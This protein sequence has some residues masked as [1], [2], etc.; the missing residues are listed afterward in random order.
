MFLW[1]ICLLGRC[2]VGSQDARRYGETHRLCLTIVDERRT[3][4]S[5]LEKLGL[6]CIFS[7]KKF[8]SYLFGHH[9]ELVTDLKP[10]LAL[11]NEHCHWYFLSGYEYTLKLRR[12]TAHENAD[13]L[14]HLP[15][16]REK[17]ASQTP[18]ALV[19]LME[20]LSE[21]SVTHQHIKTSTRRDPQLALIVQYLR[22]GWPNHGSPNPAILVKERRALIARWLHCLGHMSGDTSTRESSCTSGV[23]LRAWPNESLAR[24]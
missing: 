23:G 2:C 14:S 20:Y 8:H 22:S 19:L 7:I 11:L 24:M 4:Y 1:C 15:L 17:P 10:L 5:Q 16:Q 13:A 3:D 12:T 9:F 6:A 21:C 18:P